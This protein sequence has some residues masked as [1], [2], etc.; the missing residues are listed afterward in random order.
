MVGLP[1]PDPRSAQL[2]RRAVGADH[3]HGLPIAA[4][5]LVVQV[6]ADNGVG[7]KRFGLLDHLL[8]RQGLGCLEL[9]LVGPRPTADDI[10]DAG[11]EVAEDV[12]AHDRLAGDDPE[13]TVNGRAFDAVGCGYDHHSSLLIGIGSKNRLGLL[14]Q[15]QIETRQHP[16]LAVGHRFHIE[17]LDQFVEH[18]VPIHLRLQPGENTAEADRR[19]IHQDKLARWRH[20]ADFTKLPLDLA[21]NLGAVHG[22]A[23]FLDRLGPVLHQRLVQEPRPLIENV[24]HLAVEVAEPPGFVGMHGEIPI[25]AAERPI[26]IDDRAD[27][28]RLE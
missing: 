9:F 15:R 18:A 17:V 10:A 7:A 4:Q 19:P 12:C 27:E 8:Q 22:A 24:D 26:E 5:M 16:L 3:E 1:N 11:E 6:D 25:V 20:A 28:V 21:G 23:A 13:I 2:H 14:R